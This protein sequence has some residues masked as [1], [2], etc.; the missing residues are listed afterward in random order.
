MIDPRT[1]YILHQERINE[2]MAQIAR[3]LAAQERGNAGTI[4]QPW[5]SEVQQ[6]LIEKIYSLENCM[7]MKRILSRTGKSAAK[8]K[9]V[10]N[11]S[12]YIVFEQT[13]LHFERR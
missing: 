11:R 12:I 2:L 1:L 7:L 4:H 3:K 13:L 6:W 5:Y 8:L 9:V 10:F